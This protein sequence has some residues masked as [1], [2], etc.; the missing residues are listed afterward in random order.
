MPW[1][2]PAARMREMRPRDPR[3]LGLRGT[4]GTKLDFRGDFYTHTLM[5]PFFNPGPN[6]YGDAQDLPRRRRR[7][8]DRGRGRGVRR[9][10]LPRLHHR[11]LRP[12]GHAARRSSAAAPRRAR[13]WRASRSRARRSSSPARTRRRWRGR[14]AGHAP[15]DRVLRLDARRTA[16]CSSCTAG[17]TCRTELNALSKQGEW[18]EMGELIDDEILNTFAVV[19]E[20]EQIAPELHSAATATSSTASRSTRRT[21]PTPTAG[22]AC[23]RRSKPLDRST[24][25]CPD[26][27]DAD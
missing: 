5:T 6:P 3:D 20:P 8:D 21:A 12:R 10:H 2:H 22:G 13:R 17:A 7:A 4:N 24:Q 1:S 23:S 26:I 27:S 18:V 19:G 11:A 14:G 15:A 16:A 9:L 25:S